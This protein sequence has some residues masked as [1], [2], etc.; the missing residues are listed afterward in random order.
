MPAE[1]SVE[2]DNM[3]PADA[4][5]ASRLPGSVLTVFADRYGP[6]A[7]LAGLR[8]SFTAAAVS[9]AVSVDRRHGIV[10]LFPQGIA[11][12]VG[13]EA[14]EFARIRIVAQ[15]TGLVGTMSCSPD[16]TVTWRAACA[17]SRWPESLDAWESPAAPV[18]TPPPRS[19]AESPSG[20][21]ASD[22]AA[23]ER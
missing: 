19:A 6:A 10:T 16:G 22:T 20:S 4:D 8:Q 18:P 15:S 17:A 5:C 12:R 2:L 3:Q 13:G 11:L 7:E 9:H 14:D 23:P 1:A 21:V